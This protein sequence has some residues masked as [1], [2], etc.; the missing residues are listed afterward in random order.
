MSP[1]YFEHLKEQYF[2]QLY[3]EEVNSPEY[4]R[5]QGQL[6]QEVSGELQGGAD[7][8]LGNSEAM[9]IARMLNR[10]EV[11]EAEQFTE[12]LLEQDL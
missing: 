2:E 8:R 6:V 4:C 1:D 3:E 11:E 9:E 10:G 12:Q 5:V 7:Y